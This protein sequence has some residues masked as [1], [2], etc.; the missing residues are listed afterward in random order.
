MWA[1]LKRAFGGTAGICVPDQ[2]QNPTLTPP[3]GS[4]QHQD[5]VGA[6]TPLPLGYSKP[7]AI[8][9][10]S[11]DTQVCARMAACHAHNHIAFCTFT[12]AYVHA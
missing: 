3:C 10:S 11:R 4:Q 5:G 7:G 9:N 2:S 1:W 12:P 6:S 8:H